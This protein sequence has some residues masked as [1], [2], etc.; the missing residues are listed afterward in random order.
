M[1]IHRSLLILILA[2]IFAVIPLLAAWL[3]E[4]YLV[5]LFT[6]I[7]IFALAAIS[8]DLILGYG[9]MV[10]FGHA[11]FFGLGSYVTAILWQHAEE[12]E[13]LLGIFAGAQQALIAWPAAMAVGGLAA[14]LIGLVSLRTSGLYFIMITLAFAQMLYYFFVSFGRYG[15]E[16]G[17]ALYSRNTLP[18]LD[19][20]DPV[21]FYYVTVALLGAF[22]LLFH[23]LVDARLGAV[24]RGCRQNEQRMRALGFPVLRYKLAA[25]VIAGMAAALAGALMANHIEYTSPTFLHWKQSGEFL[26]MVALGGIG[27]LYGAVLGAGALVLLEEQLSIY[28]EHWQVILGP[29]LIAV[30]FFARRGLYGFLVR[31]SDDG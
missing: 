21:T 11:A 10:S 17:L 29:I 23:R 19:L 28:T 1:R 3:D 6:R 5:S 15:G 24:L 31:S 30:V 25:F 7:A 4:P 14:L 20:A 18:G 26:I 27:S 22:L 2:L 12:G 13:P 16:D 9:G 8:L